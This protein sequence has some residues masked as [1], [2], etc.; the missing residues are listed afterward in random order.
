MYAGS[1]GFFSFGEDSSGN[2]SCVSRKMSAW[3]SH[4]L[5]AERVVS[6]YLESFDSLGVEIV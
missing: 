2:I 3:F 6:C 5:I 4:D 1:A